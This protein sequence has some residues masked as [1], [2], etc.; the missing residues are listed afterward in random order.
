MRSRLK[1]KIVGAQDPDLA[2]A[3]SAAVG[4]QEDGLVPRMVLKLR[5][6]EPVSSGVS[7]LAFGDAARSEV[8]GDAVAEINFRYDAGGV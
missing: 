4:D 1:S 5:E 3:Q 7:A 8:P 6:R 2:R